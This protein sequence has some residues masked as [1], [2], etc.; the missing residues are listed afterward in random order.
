[1]GLVYKA[2]DTKLD[3][4]VALKFLPNRLLGDEDVRKRFEREAKASAAL[5][6]ANVCHVYE[7]DKAEDKTFISME[8]IEGESLYKTI[9]QGP[10]RLEQVLNIAQQIAAGLE[11]AH[12]KGV[13][14]RDIKPENIIIGDGGHATIMDFGL[15]QLTQAS[16]LTK[17]NQTMGTVF[18]MSPEQTE[19]ADTDHRTDIW[20]LGVVIYEMVTGQHPFK[21]DYDKAVMYSILNEESEPMTALRT[22]VPME[23]ERITGKC[24]AK[25]AAARYQ[26][27]DELLVDLKALGRG[28]ESG[29]SKTRAVPFASATIPPASILD[30]SIPAAEPRPGAAPKRMAEPSRELIAWAITAALA[31]ALAALSSIHFTETLEPQSTRKFTISTPGFG[32]AEGRPA[33]SPDGRYIAYASGATQSDLYLHDLAEGNNHTLPNT[34]GGRRPFWSP[35]SK[36]LG[37]IQETKIKRYDV[38]SDSVVTLYA[39]P[40]EAPLFIASWS[41]DGSSIAFRGSALGSI[42]QV[43]AAGGVPIPVV[44]PEREDDGLLG[45]PY[46]LPDASNR[47]RLIYSAGSPGV[48]RL[49]VQELDSAEIISLDIVASSPIYSPTGHLL[50]LD[51]SNTWVGTLWAVPFDLEATK[52]T[53]TPFIVAENVGW[54]SIDTRGT[55]VYRQ[56]PG[57]RECPNRL[58]EQ[59]RGGHRSPGEVLVRHCSTPTFCARISSA[60]GVRTENSGRRRPRRVCS[61]FRQWSRD[62]S[63]V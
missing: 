22:A 23:L 8:L 3:R 59:G 31:I 11:A 34:I 51:S 26:H 47:N 36:S 28:L 2:V 9:E 49:L 52:I 12:K 38:D 14:H 46:F 6:H 24:L 19:G 42:H 48:G 7:I 10:L 54:P 13:V 5:S 20:S 29:H 27:A 4:E 63:Y 41:P 17:A 40:S 44:T 37:F 56:D 25:D 33:I 35:D 43:S 30:T 53:G 18:Y 61:R 21:G 15:A 58:E 45:N 55:L 1:M 62:T 32:G 16:R 50:Y 60:F 39:L 57:G